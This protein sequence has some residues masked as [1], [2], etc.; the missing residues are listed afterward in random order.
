MALPSWLQECVDTPRIGDV[1]KL[2]LEEHADAIT[3]GAQRYKN[4]RKEGVKD[5]KVANLH[6]ATSEQDDIDAMGAEIAFAR[7]FGVEYDATVKPRDASH[8][9][10]DCTVN[11]KRVDVKQTV[12]V[13]GRL[14]ATKKKALAQKVDYY[15]LMIG[16]AP[17]YE[18]RGFMAKSELIQE[19]RLGSLGYDPTYIATQEELTETME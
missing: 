18:F 5:A 10:G 3:L 7:L 13:H 2:T 4:N 19:R 17:E 8:D 14:I 1:Y 11:G 6:R 12:Y 16:A 15:A 9:D